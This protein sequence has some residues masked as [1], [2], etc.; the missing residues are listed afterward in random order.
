VQRYIQ[1]ADN[2]TLCV[3]LFAASLFFAGI[4]TRLRT[5]TAQVAILVLGWVLFLGTVAWLGTFPTTV[6]V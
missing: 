5:R 6:S 1:R 2:Y 3:V 4:S